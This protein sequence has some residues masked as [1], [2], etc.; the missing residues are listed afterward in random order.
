MLSFRELIDYSVLLYED[1]KSTGSPRKRNA[2][3]IGSILN[4]WAGIESF[5]NNM[6]QD[7]ASLPEDMFTVHERGFLEEKQVKLSTRGANI[8]TFCLENKD[9]Y[10][11]LE[12]KI[13]FLIARFGKN[14]KIEKG[15]AFWQRFEKI[16]KKR[17]R[18]THP[19]RNEEIKLSLEDAK[20]AHDVSKEVIEFVFSEVWKKQIIW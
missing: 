5:I 12:D 2:F 4:S 16:K 17:N 14:K 9:E 7:F 1:A 13:A 11:R 19:R 6:M 18:L 10:K 20:D 3:I 8:G 15:T